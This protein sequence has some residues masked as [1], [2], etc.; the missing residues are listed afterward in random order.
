MSTQIQLNESARLAWKGFFVAHAL[1]VEKIESV[2]EDS[3]AGS[4]VEYDALYTIASSP[5]REIEAK[6]LV[7]SVMLSQ[8]GLSRLLGRLESRGLVERKESP[9]DGRAFRVTITAKG[10]ESLE[11]LWEVYANGIHEHF[12]QHLSTSDLDH[13]LVTMRKIIG[14]LADAREKTHR[15][16]FLH[17]V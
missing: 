8:S 15:A 17:R 13:L 4:L 11:Q 5:N 14:P 9:T 7:A 16:P 1:V 6:D 2:I 12:A 3:G 10:E